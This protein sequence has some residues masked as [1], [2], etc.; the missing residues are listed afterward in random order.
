MNCFRKLLRKRLATVAFLIN[1]QFLVF[2]LKVSYAISSDQAPAPSLHHFIPGTV[3]ESRAEGQSLCPLHSYLLFFQSSK[4]S[5]SSQ[6]SKFQGKWLI[7]HFS[8]LVSWYKQK[9]KVLIYG[10]IVCENLSPPAFY[11]SPY[12]C[13]YFNFC[14]L[15]CSSSH[16]RTC[17]PELPWQ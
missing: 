16:W 12:I 17:F 15:D 14:F 8:F 13:V 1:G 2:S 7:L 5:L 9:K 10:S 3:F 11:V 4:G 6:S